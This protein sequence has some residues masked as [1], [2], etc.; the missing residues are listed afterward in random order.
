[1]AEPEI[2]NNENSVELSEEQKARIEENH[3]KALE[4]KRKRQN[5]S[6][7]AKYVHWYPDTYYY[8]I[9]SNIEIVM[10]FL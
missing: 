2:A 3:K 5:S 4:L 8:G 10:L 6:L 9:R 1:M 7:S